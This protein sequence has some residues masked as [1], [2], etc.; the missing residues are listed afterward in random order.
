MS[1]PDVGGEPRSWAPPVE[2]DRITSARPTNKELARGV[3]QVHTCL[4]DHRNHTS[5]EFKHVRSDLKELRAALIDKKTVATQTPGAAWVRTFLASGGAIAACG[6][7]LRLSEVL[8][9]W[10]K[11]ASVAV[12]HAMQAGKL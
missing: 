10:F 6:A 1:M 5:R 8:W 12:F 3:D 7:V 4:E 11:G 2:F 9:P